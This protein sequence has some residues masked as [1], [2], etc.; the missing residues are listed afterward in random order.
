MNTEGV[1]KQRSSNTCELCT[2]SNNLS[3]YPVPLN[4]SG[5]ASDSI[6]IC[7]KCKDQLTHKDFLD[8]KHW[9]CLQTCMW[10]EVAAVQVVA[11][12]ML[13]RCRAESWAAD[14][15]DIIYLSDENLEWAKQTN[16]H[17]SEGNDNFHLDS[18]GAILQDGD[19]VIL[20]KTLDVKG[21]SVNAKI[22]TIVHNI[23]LVKDNNEQIE[24]RI[25]GQMIVI[26]TKYL[27]KN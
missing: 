3:I 26:L 18:N 9:Q 22:G 13:N 7:I 11:W 6:Y 12:R 24:G 21:S 14:A 4:S 2:A 16:D 25:D 27:R 1:L 8:V 17:L 10:S 15:L 23:K 20:I 19:N 5:Q